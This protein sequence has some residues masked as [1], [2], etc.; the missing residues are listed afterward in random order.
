[1]YFYSKSQI[2]VRSDG[3]WRDGVIGRTVDDGAAATHMQVPRDRRRKVGAPNSFW[4][5]CFFLLLF[6]ST[7][8]YSTFIIY[9]Y[10]IIQL[11]ITATIRNKNGSI[12][13]MQYTR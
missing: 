1:M 6:G 5:L 4:F 7:L 3:R 12:I 9:L 2:R 11:C 8:Y 10:I 13:C